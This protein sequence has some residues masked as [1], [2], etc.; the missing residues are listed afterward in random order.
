MIKER[1]NPAIMITMCLFFVMGFF[2]EKGILEQ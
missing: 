2:E 1:A